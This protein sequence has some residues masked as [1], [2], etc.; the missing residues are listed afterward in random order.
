M[1][2]MGWSSCSV[3]LCIERVGGGGL[4]FGNGREGW[5]LLILLYDS[6]GAK[7]KEKTKS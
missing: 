5:A 3:Y 7:I 2:F 6:D 1:V 4:R